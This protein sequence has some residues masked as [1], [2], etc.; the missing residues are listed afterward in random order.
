LIAEVDGWQSN[1]TRSAFEDDR[2][3]DARLRLLG[4]DVLR[5]T[6]RQLEDDGPAVAKIIRALLHAEA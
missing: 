5:F 3:R 1:G 2:A 4:F 6:W